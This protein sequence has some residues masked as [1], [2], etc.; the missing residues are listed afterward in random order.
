LPGPPLAAEKPI[1]P[2]LALIVG[3]AGTCVADGDRK[4]FVVHV[5]RNHDL[6]ARR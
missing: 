2:F 4:P 5:R 6:G 1:P 3:Q